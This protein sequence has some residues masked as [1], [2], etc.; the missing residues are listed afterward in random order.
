[1]YFNYSRWLLKA[2][3]FACCFLLFVPEAL[4]QEQ[5]SGRSIPKPLRMVPLSADTYPPEIQLIEPQS[6]RGIGVRS[7]RAVLRVRGTVVDDNPIAEFTIDGEDVLLNAGGLF[8]TEISLRPGVNLIAL[9]AVDRAGNEASISVSVVREMSLEITGDYYAFVIGINEYSGDWP[10]L[11]NAVHDASALAE[12]LREEYQFDEVVT[13]FDAAATRVNIINQ[14]EWYAENL[15]ED[16]NLLIYY[17]GHGQLVERFNR[18]YWV[19]VDATTMSIAQMIPNTDIQTW[20]GGIPAHHTL[21][22]ADACFAGDVFRAG[23][24]QMRKF[25]GTADY[26]QAVYRDKSRKALTSGG[27]EPVLDGGRDGHSVFTYYLL[28]ALRENVAELM[29]ATEMFDRILYPV[30]NNSDQTPEFRPIKNA[31]DEGGQFIFVR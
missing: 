6:M 5:T 24:T 9:R 4:S 17:S 21:L 18:G 2:I 7:K 22:I 28:K 31:G 12:V 20:I 30:V 8:D 1:M 23:P 16:D 29:D 15:D 14:I 11:K 26:Y 3:V 25:E 13:L 10:V 27:I 19:P